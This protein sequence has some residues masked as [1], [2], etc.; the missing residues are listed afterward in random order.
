[1]RAESRGRALD[2][3]VDGLEGDDDLSEDEE[4]R[5]S[6]LAEEELELGAYS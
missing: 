2:L 1:M 6:G 4:F 5:L 3:K